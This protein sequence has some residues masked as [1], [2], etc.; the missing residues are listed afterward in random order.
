MEAKA[1]SVIIQYD[2]LVTNKN[3]Q[4]LIEQ[5]YGPKGISFRTQVMAYF[6]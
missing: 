2:D 4:P 6:L 5:A 1:T 3:L